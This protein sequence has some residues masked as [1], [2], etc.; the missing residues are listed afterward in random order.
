MMVHGGGCNPHRSTTAFFRK[1]GN[2][3]IDDVITRKL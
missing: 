2:Y 3:V 1:P